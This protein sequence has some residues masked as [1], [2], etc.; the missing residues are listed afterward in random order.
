MQIRH[1]LT[2]WNLSLGRVGLMWRWNM[3]LREALRTW[4]LQ[5]RADHGYAAAGPLIVEWQ[6]DRLQMGRIF[7]I[8]GRFCSP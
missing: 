2:T 5:R 7:T 3:S 1:G 8:A 4:Q 6:R